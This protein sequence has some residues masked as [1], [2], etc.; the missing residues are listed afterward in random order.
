VVAW[1]ERHR[2]PRLVGTTAL[3]ALLGTATA[4]AAYGLRDEARDV[5]DALPR[6]AEQVRALVWSSERPSPVGQIQEAAEVLQGSTSTSG[7]PGAGSAGPAPDAAASGVQRGIGSLVALAGHATVILFLVF[8]LLLA[9]SHFRTRLVELAGRRLEQ[10]RITATIIDD[11]NAQIQRFLLMRALTAVVVALATWAVLAWMGAGQPALWG[12]LA[13]VFNSI[14]YFGPVI[15][16]GGLL[17]VGLVQSGDPLRAIAMSGAA[18]GITSLE[19]WLLTPALMGRAAR[20]NVVV[21]FLGVL[22][23]TWIWGA[24]GTLLAVPMLVVVK[25][26]ADHVEALRPLRRLMDP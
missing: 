5:L 23:W 16:S 10:R 25:A 4:G 20:M 8:F 13:G 19:G 2:V 21:V 9:G 22:F 15:V 17:V 11:V 14:P 3:L 7:G 6:A 1:L 24:W 26:V 12:A 18:L